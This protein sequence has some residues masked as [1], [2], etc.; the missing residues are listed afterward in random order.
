VAIE[1]VPRLL[2]ERWIARL[3]A[4]PEVVALGLAFAEA[5]GTPIDD[6]ASGARRGFV[7]VGEEREA[8]EGLL[9][10]EL[11]TA[12]LAGAANAKAAADLLDD[13]RVAVLTEF[14]RD[15]EFARLVGLSRFVRASP[16]LDSD[17]RRLY[18]SRSLTFVVRYLNPI[19]RTL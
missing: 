12:I 14:Q 6:I 5:P 3:N 15:P 2:R 10:L 4:A 13:A 9:D 18:G 11:V 19:A 7:A 8:G 1:N 16:L 17:G